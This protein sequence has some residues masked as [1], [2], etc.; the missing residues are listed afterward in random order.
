MKIKR[1]IPVFAPE[2][3]A[4]V[5][6]ETSGRHIGCFCD[7]CIAAFNAETGGKWTRETLGKA[8][9][10]DD[11]VCARWRGTRCAAPR[12]SSSLSGPPAVHT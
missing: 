3:A 9:A 6:C 2:H 5:L 4:A 8:V 1:L 12:Q 7:T 11:A 10:E